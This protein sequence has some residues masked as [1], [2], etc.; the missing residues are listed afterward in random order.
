MCS[1]SRRGGG[2]VGG[3]NNVIEAQGR[4]VQSGSALVDIG[5][6]NPYYYDLPY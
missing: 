4:G 6:E 5:L 2:A 3:E 1:R